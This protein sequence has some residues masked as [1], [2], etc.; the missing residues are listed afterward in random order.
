MTRLD[1]KVKVSDLEFGQRIQSEKSEVENT[2]L[3]ITRGSNIHV[4]NNHWGL[5]HCLIS[6]IHYLKSQHVIKLSFNVCVCMYI[7]I[8][9]KYM[10]Y[11]Y[12]YIYTHTPVYILNTY[13]NSN[14][15][16][17]ES[18]LLSNTKI[19]MTIVLNSRTCHKDSV[20]FYV[21]PLKEYLCIIV[22]RV[23]NKY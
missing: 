4:W 18:N 7:F 21:K 11:I 6:N 15:G 10:H 20:L 2:I 5:N 13:V 19:G 12:L 14:S 16:Y 17:M 8:I 1:F 22:P 3:A 23:F 9:C